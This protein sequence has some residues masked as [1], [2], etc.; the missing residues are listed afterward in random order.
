MNAQAANDLALKIA[1]ALV[2]VL[3]DADAIAGGPTTAAEASPAGYPPLKC[4]AC[5]REMR[6]DEINWYRL[7]DGMELCPECMARHE[8]GE[9]PLALDRD[10]EA[11]TAAGEDLRRT[12]F[13]Y[14]SYTPDLPRPWRAKISRPDLERNVDR[15]YCETEAEAVFRVIEELNAIE[16]PELRASAV[17]K[18]IA[19]SRRKSERVAAEPDRS[20]YALEAAR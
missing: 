4:E 1:E 15:G 13:R 11:A 8:A 5:R 20:A 2:P 14:V 19:A 6:P 3:I 16:D 17:A 7:A 10:A 18:W 12:C 9:L